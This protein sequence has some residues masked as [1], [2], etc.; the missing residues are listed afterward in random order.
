MG[1]SYILRSDDGQLYRVSKEQLEAFK[2]SPTDP[3]Q[4]QAGDLAKIADVAK[5]AAMPIHADA[6]CL[7]AMKDKGKN[8][9]S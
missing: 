9:S 3:A 6:V 7:I 5:K 4:A 1:D 2:L 8:T